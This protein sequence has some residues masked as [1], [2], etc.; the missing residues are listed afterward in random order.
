[1]RYEGPKPPTPEPLKGEEIGS[2]AHYTITQRFPRIVR[3]T[4]K[5]NEFPE[6]VETLLLTLIEEIPFA[7]IRYLLDSFA[8]DAEDWHDYLELY[9]EGRVEKQSS[10]PNW[11]QVPWFFVETYFY[12]RILEATGYFHD[13]PDGGC[14]PFIYQK[15]LGL[16][17]FSR[18]IQLIAAMLNQPNN[19]SEDEKFEVLKQLLLQDIWGNQADLSMWPVGGEKGPDHIKLQQQVSHLLVND[20]DAVLGHLKNMKPGN[21]RIDLIAD[22]ASLE[23][24]GDLSVAD[25]IL[26][27]EIAQ[28]FHFH[29]KPHPTFVSDAMIKDVFESVEF[30]GNQADADIQALASRLKSLLDAGRLLLHDDLFWTSPLSGWEMPAHMRK[31]FSRSNLII[32]KGDANYRRLL[33]DRHWQFD[34]HLGEILRYLPAP[35]LALRVLKS[36]VAAGMPTSTLEEMQEKDPDWLVDGV[37]GVIQFANQ[38]IRTR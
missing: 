38:V 19:K 1:M 5:D 15:N 33:G 7:P 8:P 4:I 26:N 16:D 27:C 35:I 3:Q 36:E 28:T 10:P 2:F 21:T 17:Q 31:E 20:W 25:F 32:S 13:P 6:T 24:I 22:N 11:L 14:D 29:L 34:T 9:L 18:Q 37:W 23:L 12:R 30:L